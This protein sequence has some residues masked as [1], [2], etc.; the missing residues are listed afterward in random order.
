LVFFCIANEDV[1]R[2]R[3]LVES[4]KTWGLDGVI[5]LPCS[6]DIAHFDSFRDAGIPYVFLDRKFGDMKN[7]IST[8]N[9]YGAWRMTKYVISMGHSNISAAFPSFENQIYKERY[10]GTLKA[11]KEHGLS[12]CAGSFLFNLKDM[13]DAWRKTCKLLQSPEKPTAIV[14]ASDMLCLA[15][16][17]ASRTCG[18]Q[19]PKD[20]SVTG[21]GDAPI[22]SMIIPPLTTYRQDEEELARRSVDY[23]LSC[24]DGAPI[25]CGQRLQGEIVIRQSVGR[26]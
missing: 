11:L 18:L 8:D 15:I 17:G 22:A 24:I 25:P 13:Q 4:L 21:Y 7:C 12:H 10:E 26:V 14:A 2:E 23:L 9:F 1:N 16:Y 20:L 19:L 6:G 5:V 3:Q